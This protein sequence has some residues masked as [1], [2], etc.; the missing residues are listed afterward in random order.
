MATPAATAAG[1]RKR[2]RGRR[3]S[4]GPRL[5]R[6]L[7]ARRRNRRSV[8]GYPRQGRKPAHY[9]LLGAPRRRVMA[10]ASSQHLPYVEDFGPDVLKAKAAGI[11]GYKIH[12]GGGQSAKRQAARQLRGPH[13][14]DQASPQGCR[15][16]L[17]AQCSTPSKATTSTRPSSRTAAGRSGLHCVRRPTS[18]HRYRSLIV[19]AKALDVPLN[20]GEFIMNIQRFADYIKRDAL[21]I[22]RFIAD[23]IGGNHRRVAS[24]PTG[25]GFSGWKFSRTTGAT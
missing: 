13:G 1:R 6:R 8:C 10:Y 9:K 18:H 21:D 24:V 25:R 3:R 16:R 12:P 22:V 4:H 23:N 20:I 17:P 2:R 14:G 5:S 15:R 7:P 19:L 11:R